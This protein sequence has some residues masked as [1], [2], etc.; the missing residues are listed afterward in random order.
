VPA[1]RKAIVSL[2][3]GDQRPLLRLARTSVAPYARRHGYD[4]LVSTRLLAPERPPAWSKV[5]AL[6]ALQERYD[7]LVWLDADLMVVD[8]REDLAA[9]LD[10]DR[11]AF[12][13]LV[14]HDTPEGRVPNSGVLVLRTGERCGAFLQAVWDQEDLVHHRW[15]ENAAICRLLGYG[16]DPVRRGPST[17]W[18][19]ATRFL[20]PRWN[21]IPDAPAA[22]PRIRHYPGYK[23]R[24]RALLM[25]RD[26]PVA[27]ARAHGASLPAR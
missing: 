26:L 1:V 4:L 24:T 9:E 6:Q 22:A 5:R 15:W 17:P 20:D 12:M 16:L 14:E 2:A 8:P 19:E 27:L 21:A 18:R 11:D 10:G 25:A 7:L 13:A 23:V 3:T